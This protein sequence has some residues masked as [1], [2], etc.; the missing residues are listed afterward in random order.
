[1]RVAVKG[2]SIA[3]GCAILRPMD[4]LTAAPRAG[5]GKAA[6]CKDMTQGSI[7]RQLV[8]FAVPLILGNFFQLTYNAVDSIILG[9]F[10]GKEALAAAGIANP[11]MNIMI[12]CIVG[13][14]W[15]AGVLISEFY[16]RKDFARLKSEVS[17]TLVV[18]FAFTVIVSAACF[19]LAVP[20]L[21][22]VRAPAQL[23]AS[24]AWYLRIIFCGLP[25]TFF[26]NM[27]AAAL[28]AIGD[29]K[30]PIVCVAVSAVLNGALDFVLVAV[31]G[32]GMTGAAVA[33]VAAQAVACV[34]CVG[35]VYLRSPLVAVHPCDFHVD[36]S[37]LRKTAS[38]SLAGAM[39]QTVL[40][41]GKLL[42]Q[43]AVNPLGV[44][45]I[46]TFNAGTKVDDFC[47]QPEQSIGQA[48]T[49]LVAQNRGAGNYQ[50]I[51]QGL[52][53]GLLIEFGYGVLIGAAVIVLRGPLMHLFAGADEAEVLRLGRRYLLI[54]ALLYTLPAVTNGIQ[55]FFRG[56]GFMNVTVVATTVQM[57]ARAGCSLLLAPRFG[58]AGIA[59]SCGIGWFCMM[60]YEVPLLVRWRASAW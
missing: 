24:S 1:M 51:R 9:R 18:G 31:C 10:A 49:T 11:I 39:Q 60:V 44:D 59:I 14:S 22:L 42:V 3:A 29:S 57:T 33:T 15:G 53:R 47:Y 32:L 43:S 37:L 58:I 20:I 56:M 46:A 16:G 5:H 23:R 38:Y 41:V 17:T 7:S 6:L 28:R 13:I 35:F 52:W 27:F 30:T 48:M 45:A 34:L 12:F 19:A 8:T 26:Y 25:C 2:Y 4:T 54:M 50:R 55:G 36:A 40:Y 21:R